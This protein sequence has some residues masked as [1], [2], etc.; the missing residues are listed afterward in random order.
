M[1]SALP[2]IVIADSEFEVDLRKLEF[3]QRG[4]PHNRISFFDISI[5]QDRLL[6]CYDRK[7]KNAF[8]GTSQK[9]KL[10]SFVQI[11]QL[12][13]LRQLDPFNYS[14]LITRDPQHFESLAKAA[15]VFKHAK[16][17]INNPRIVKTK[18]YGHSL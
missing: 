10:P 16:P 5:E 3:R 14:L 17:V 9:G 2:T 7:I 1:S 13:G 6:L 15:E 11:V 8:R 12:P 18:K 4:H